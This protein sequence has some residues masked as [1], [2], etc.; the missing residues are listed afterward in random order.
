ME[1]LESMKKIIQEYVS[2]DLVFRLVDVLKSINK[3]FEKAT[4]KKFIFKVGSFKSFNRVLEKYLR[5]NLDFR[6]IFGIYEQNLWN[7]PVKEFFFLSVYHTPGYIC[8]CS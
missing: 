2:D 1:V 5:R 7:T 3:M 8:D 6:K 4:L